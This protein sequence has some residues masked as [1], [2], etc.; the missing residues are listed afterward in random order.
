MATDQLRGKVALLEIQL[1]EYVAVARAELQDHLQEL[2]ILKGS[3]SEAEKQLEALRLEALKP[4]ENRELPV[5]MSP[6]I[7]GDETGAKKHQG[8]YAIEK[9]HIGRNTTPISILSSSPVLLFSSNKEDL[10]R[11]QPEF[12]EFLQHMKRLMF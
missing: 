3:L 10:L 1:T 2:E 6:G 11:T 5:C 12:Q 7:P 9:P 8:S 4:Q